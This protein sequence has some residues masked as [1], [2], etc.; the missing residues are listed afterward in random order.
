MNEN[1]G[2]PDP[3]QERLAE[4]AERYCQALRRGE[5][6]ELEAYAAEMPELADEIREVFPALALMEHAGERHLGAP[7][8]S[9]AEPSA[10]APAGEDFVARTVASLEAQG[11]SSGRYSSENEI[12]RGGQGGAYRYRFDEL[13]NLQTSSVVGFSNQTQNGELAPDRSGMTDEYLVRLE[14]QTLELRSSDGSSVTF[15][16]VQAGEFPESSI[17]ALERRRGG[18]DAWEDLTDGKDD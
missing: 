5:R 10:E 7:P 14:N 8:A 18:V 16:R 12:A 17:R 2:A 15:R 4:L 11:A 3:N 13:A 6:P 1:E 9:V